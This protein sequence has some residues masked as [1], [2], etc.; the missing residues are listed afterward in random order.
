MSTRNSLVK[1]TIISVLAFCSLAFADEELTEAQL[2][3]QDVQKMIDAVYA[4]DIDTLIGYTHPEIIEL[5]GGEEEAR[6]AL[7]EALSQLAELNMTVESMTYPSEPVF[8]EGGDSRFVIVPTLS[9]IAANGRRVESLNYQFG[10]L[11]AGASTWKYVEGSRINSDN[12]QMLFPDF[13]DDYEFPETYRH[14]IEE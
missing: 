7:T 8:L 12:V 11:D 2:V 4:N 1:I 6:T 14:L 5:M 10:I 3:Q 9:I 13:P